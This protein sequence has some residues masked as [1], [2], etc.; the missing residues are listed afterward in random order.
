L[1]L[2]EDPDHADTGADATARTVPALDWSELL[3]ARLRA[4]G[5]GTRNYWH[6]VDGRYERGE[7]GETEVMALQSHRPARLVWDAVV[8]SL[9]VNARVKKAGRCVSAS[10]EIQQRG[11]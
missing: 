10:K 7:E 4:G 11:L 9:S 5:G 8:R 2:Q 1:K 3:A 6:S